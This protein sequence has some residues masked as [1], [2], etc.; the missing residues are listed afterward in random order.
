MAKIAT[1]QELLQVRSVAGR[2]ANK[3]RPSLR[4]KMDTQRHGGF[5]TFFLNS[6][7]KTLL[8]DGFDS[9]IISFTGEVC[10]LRAARPKTLS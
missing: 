7:L 2:Q 5:Y 10:L 6:N 8:T 3:G 1:F 4:A 9:V